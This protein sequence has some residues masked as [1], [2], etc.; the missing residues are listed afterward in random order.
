MK[1]KAEETSYN[2]Y[3]EDLRKKLDDSYQVA[4]KKMNLAHGRSKERYDRKVRGNKLE[5]GDRVLVRKTKFEE[6]RH[7]LA[8]KW[9][10]KVFVV[11]EKLDNIPVYKLRP[12]D[13]RGKC[14]RLHRNNILPISSKGTRPPTDESDTSSESSIEEICVNDQRMEQREENEAENQEQNEEGEERAEEIEESEETEE[15]EESRG[16]IQETQPRPEGAE[17]EVSSEEEPSGQE[18]EDVTLPRRSGRERRLPER[19]RS[20]DYVMSQQT[21]GMDNQKYILLNRVLDLLK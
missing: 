21:T 17:R 5:V 9:E 7:K 10:D 20:G 13:G 12:E 2:D 18:V 19:F 3:V 8:N 15:Q 4:R 11:E 6:G 1:A 14:R 16:R